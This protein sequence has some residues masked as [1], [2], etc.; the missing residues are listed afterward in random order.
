MFSRRE[1]L[2]ISRISVLSIALAV[3]GCQKSV[4]Y[5]TTDE[6][7]YI[8]PTVAVMSFTNQAPIRMKWN[9][10]DGLADQLIDRLIQTRRYVVLER[11]QLRTVLEELKRSQDRR[12]REIGS[13]QPSRNNHV[14]YLVKGTITDFGPVENIQGLGK[15]FGSGSY[16]VVAATIYLVD[17]QNGQIIASESIVAKVRDKREKKEEKVKYEGMAF[18]SYAFYRTP[19]GCATSQLLDKALRSVTRTIADQPYQPKIASLLNDRVI[20]NGGLDRLIKVGSEY[21]VRPES[22]VVIDPDTGDIIGH[23]TGETL[24]RVR[25]TQVT[26]K[27]AVAA[28]ISGSDFQPGQTLFL[29]PNPDTVRAPVA[30]SSY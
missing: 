12:S 7:R 25:V 24:G 30:S 22:Q 5:S 27:Y 26:A 20:I 19:L 23:I 13:P 8:K 3:L 17:V 9:L 11:Q 18:G 16:A 10:G 14:R 1:N 4:R 28:I 21:T 15:L 6:A 29:S 2:S